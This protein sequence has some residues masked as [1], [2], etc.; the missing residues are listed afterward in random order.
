MYKIIFQI[1]ENEATYNNTNTTDELETVQPTAR[2]TSK[3][4][5]ELAEF[6]ESH[7]TAAENN[8]LDLSSSSSVLSNVSN[9]TNQNPTVDT[10]SEKTSILPQ[11]AEDISESYHSH[12]NSSIIPEARTSELESTASG[13][14]LPLNEKNGIRKCTSSLFI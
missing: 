6:C 1:T 3:D 4:L 14:L 10:Q 8:S 13:G 2:N 5:T 7:Q 11:T 12:N 9:P